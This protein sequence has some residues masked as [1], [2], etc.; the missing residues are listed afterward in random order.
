MCVPVHANPSH[1]R[2]GRHG[3]ILLLDDCATAPR[4]RGY[5]VGKSEPGY[6]GGEH[7]H[8]SASAGAFR[9]RS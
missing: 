7:G 1:K 8:R 5:Y 4:D 3:L 9:V 6:V 2:I